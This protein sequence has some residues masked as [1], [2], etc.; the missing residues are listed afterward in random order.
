VLGRNSVDITASSIA[1]RG[2]I[3]APTIDADAC[4]W[5]AGMPNGSSVANTDGN[6]TPA[7]APNQSPPQVTGIALTAGTRLSFR[8]VGGTTAYLGSTEYGPDGQEDWIVRQ[9]PVNGINSTRAPLNSLVGIF[10][11][12]R[13]PNTWAMA[14]ELDFTTPGSRNFSSLSPGLKQVFF[15]GDG[16][17]NGGQLQEFVVPTGAT[18][19]YLGI[20]DEKGW[21]WDNTGT[22]STSMMNQKVT[23][24]K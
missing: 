4:P 16:M 2:Q 1:A 13:A 18:R 8:Q 10:L 5:L 17:T 15:I 19:L 23:I 9:A 22:L 21:W 12:D 11:D 14:G 6:P 7:T 20:M 3:V 24:V